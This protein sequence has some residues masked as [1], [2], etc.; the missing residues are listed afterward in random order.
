M[1]LVVDEKDL[2]IIRTTIEPKLDEIRSELRSIFDEETVK[3]IE[4][5]RREL[6][7]LS[8]EDLLSPFTI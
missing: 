5:T 7:I 4:N 6:S 2:E 3:E 1:L 8:T